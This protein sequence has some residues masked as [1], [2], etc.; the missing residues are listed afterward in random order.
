M[1]FRLVRLDKG[2]DKLNMK[3]P[4]DPR[5]IVV[6]NHHHLGDMLGSFP[7]LLA[8]RQRWPEARILNVAPSLPLSLLENTGLTDVSIAQPRT[9]RGNWKALRV[10]RSQKPDLAV[11]FSG[12]RRVAV[13]ARLC[14]ARH[15]IGYSPTK[16]E[17]AW[18][19]KVSIKGAPAL[20]HDLKMAET[21]GCPISKR[22][23]V[24][25]LN[26]TEGECQVATRW[27]NENGVREGQPLIGLNMG[28]SVDR[29][30]WG[31]Q[32]FA[33]VANELSREGLRI[34]VFGGPNDVE[35]VE[36]LQ[37]MVAE[38]LLVATGRFS[39]RESAA[40]MQQ[41]AVMLTSDTGPMHLSLI[42]DTPTV[43][44]F[45]IVPASYRL[46]P[47]RQHIGL[48]H[49]AECQRLPQP[50]CRYKDQCGC[51]LSIHPREVVD[52]VREILNREHI[53]V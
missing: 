26:V 1:R 25:L 24:G 13:M 52:A 17:W 33:A 18:T 53:I 34:V 46:P 37:K 51:L 45:G 10:V 20:Q 28:A 8:I 47:G 2:L 32:N 11:C 23:Y 15:R 4:S 35:L 14:G 5:T 3:M 16:H 38:P 21:L 39:P 9:A 30:R 19:T 6:F 36:E 40:L 50:R 48:E 22:D 31:V 43:A 29:R 42:V 7:A 27:L 44:L 41:C 49:N 12:T